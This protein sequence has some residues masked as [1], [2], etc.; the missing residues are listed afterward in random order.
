PGP[1]SGTPDPNCRTK[2]AS[3]P[4][5]NRTRTGTETPMV[6]RKEATLVVLQQ[7]VHEV[8]DRQHPDGHAVVQ[9]DEMP[10][11]SPAHR[12]RGLHDVPGRG[13]TDRRRGHVDANRGM[14]Q[15]R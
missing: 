12:L 6:S 14:G 9:H 4:D 7:G 3:E 13:G 5:P 8:P 15:V 1:P 2:L 11:P 10:E